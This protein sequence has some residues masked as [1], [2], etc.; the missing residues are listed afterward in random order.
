MEN[1]RGR[2]IIW[3]TPGV[4]L[5]H[6]KRPGTIYHMENARGRFITLKTPAEIILT[7]SL[8]A[9]TA[10]LTSTW[11]KLLIWMLHCVI[12]LMYWKLSTALRP[13]AMPVSLLLRLP[14][15]LS[16]HYFNCLLFLIACVPHWLCLLLCSFALMNF[17][18]IAAEALSTVFALLVLQVSVAWLGENKHY[19]MVQ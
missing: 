4:D 11:F 16:L 2:F 3:K 13:H 12:S 9:F 5:S 8:I 10:A 18:N 1:A 19:Y 6:G 14:W 7:Y 15:L 17:Q